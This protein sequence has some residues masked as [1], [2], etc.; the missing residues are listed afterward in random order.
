[1][2]INLLGP[3]Q[4][5]GVGPFKK[6]QSACYF[7]S[8]WEEQSAGFSCNRFHYRKFVMLKQGEALLEWLSF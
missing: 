3:F 2:E 8:A 6:K 5:W 4:S 7:G 1:M